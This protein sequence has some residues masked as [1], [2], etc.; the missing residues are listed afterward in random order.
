MRRA[1]LSDPDNL[2]LSARQYK[3]VQVIEDSVRCNGYV[4][5]LREIAKAVGLASTSSVSYQLSVLAEK[6]Y[7]TR[8]ARRPRTA[9]IKH[10]AQRPRRS[11]AGRQETA[12]A[13]EWRQFRLSAGSR[14][15]A[16]FSWTSPLRMSSLCQ[17]NWS[18][19]GT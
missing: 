18:G 6:G 11:G 1:E 3:I 16:R 8:E 9:V 19:R 7:L 12:T 13:R 10:P 4:P 17:G 2:G 14:R 5:S 15:E